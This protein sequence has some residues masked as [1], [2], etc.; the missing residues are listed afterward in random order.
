MLMYRS[1]RV[2]IWTRNQTLLRESLKS[3]IGCCA[4]DTGKW[5]YDYPSYVSI[6]LIFKSHWIHCTAIDGRSSLFFE[7]SDCVAGK[8]MGQEVTALPNPLHF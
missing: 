8:L 6:R 3:R 5:N 4:A 7:I 2:L 1:Y